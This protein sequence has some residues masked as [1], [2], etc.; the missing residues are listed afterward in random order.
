[1]RVSVCMATYNGE[2][3]IAKQIDSI[4]NQ[5]DN[6]DEMVISDDSST[7]DTRVIIARYAQNDA[8]IKFIQGPCKGF[9]KNFENAIKNASGNIIVFADQDD[10]WSEGKVDKIRAVF[11]EK[12]QYTTVLHTMKT[13]YNDQCY[14]NTIKVKYRKGVL[15][16]WL[17]SCYWGCCMAVK[18]EFI[19]KMLPFPDECISHD[20]L[21]GLVSEKKGATYFLNE[22]LIMHRIHSSNKTRKL[23][24]MDKLIFRF[25]LCVQYIYC[26]HNWKEK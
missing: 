10:I 16:N 1:M 23:P 5:L 17:K 19:N 6:E 13:F 25:K 14:E 22:D 26:I 20:Q 18:Y 9:A 4:L 2:K 24:L 11:E 21:I 7:D 15:V 8:R 12:T 3:Y